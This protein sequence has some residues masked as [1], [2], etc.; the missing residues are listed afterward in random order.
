MHLRVCKC[1]ASVANVK[2]CEKRESD[3]VSDLERVPAHEL[4]LT[5]VRLF[6]IV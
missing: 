6:S 4:T 2:V 1:S 5:L 3:K